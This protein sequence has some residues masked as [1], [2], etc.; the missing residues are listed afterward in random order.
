[1]LLFKLGLDDEGA[2]HPPRRRLPCGVEG[3]KPPRH[4]SEA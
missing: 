3:A 2:F 1:M 4:R